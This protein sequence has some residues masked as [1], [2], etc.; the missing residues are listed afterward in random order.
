MGKKKVQKKRLKENQEALRKTAEAIEIKENTMQ[1]VNLNELNKF[2]KIK[3][4]RDLENV[5]ITYGDNEKD[6][7]KDFQEMYD[8]I[9]NEIEVQDK[10]NGYTLKKIKLFI[11]YLINL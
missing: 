9:N 7:F 10:K 6:K 5:I 2:E 4:F 8:L 3:K 11:F 1:D